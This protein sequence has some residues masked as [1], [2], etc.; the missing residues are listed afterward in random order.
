VLPG[1]SGS[2]IRRLIARHHKDRLSNRFFLHWL[3]VHS[4]CVD[5]I[6]TTSLGWKHFDT[7]RICKGYSR[8]CPVL[9]CA[10]TLKLI[11]YRP[12]G[13]RPTVLPY[14]HLHGIRLHTGTFVYFDSERKGPDQAR[15]RNFALHADYVRQH[16]LDSPDKAET[17]RLGYEMS[18]DALS[19]NVFVNLLERGRLR[20]AS[21]WLI[22]RSLPGDPE[23]YMWG[24]RIA[25]KGGDRG[26]FSPLLE[27]RK[28]LEPKIHKFPTEP[29]IMLVVPGRAVVC[30]EA[31]FTSG[32]PVSSDTPAKDGEKPKDIRGLI[33]RYL[34]ANPIL[35]GT[36]IIE[37]GRIGASV[38]SQL[39]RNVVFAASMAQGMDWH[40]VNLTREQDWVGCPDRDGYS[41][42]D[43]TKSVRTYL[44]ESHQHRFTFRT[45]EG[46]Y[47]AT[48]KQDGELSDLASYLEGKSARFLPAFALNQ[49]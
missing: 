27:V 40:V 46:L 4:Y 37:T 45:W 7:S 32:N 31:K 2:W 24:S 28:L 8:G 6:G 39:F 47:R 44:T 15:L 23:L 12:K 18:E 25:T 9:G 35:R 21:E 48:V 17:H 33:N 10:A 16:V 38:H 14:C 13:P 34:E 19:W 26:V 43:P 36:G 22:G 41:F 3:R 49:R 11:P 42:S 20:A 1:L 5:S 29:D 30:I